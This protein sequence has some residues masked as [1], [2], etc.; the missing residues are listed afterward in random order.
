MSW[1]HIYLNYDQEALALYANIGL[2]RRARKD[3]EANKVTL[4]EKNNEDYL[5]FEADG[6]QVRLSAQGIQAASCNC[7]ALGHCKHIISAVLWLQS[8][9]SLLDP[10]TDSNNIDDDNQIKPL[11][12]SNDSHNSDNKISTKQLE[13]IRPLA[14]VLTELLSLDASKLLKK[15]GKANMFTAYQLVCDWQK[16]PL[17]TIEYQDSQIRIIVPESDTPIIY[18]A[19]TGFAG[20]ISA[21]P[22]KQKMAVHLAVIAYLFEQNNKI[23]TWPI[24]CRQS[25]MHEVDQLSADEITLIKQIQQHIYTLIKQGLSHVSHSQA[26]QLQL[27][28]M[29]ARSQGLPRLAAMLRHLCQ[30]IE[31]LAKRHFTVEE[32]DILLFLGQVKAYTE[33]LLHHQGEQLF[34]L[35]GRIKRQYKT[36]LQTLDLLPLGGRWWQSKTGAIGATFYFWDSEKQQY[37]ETT[38]A[39]SYKNNI[40]FNRLMVWNS[41]SIWQTSPYMLMQKAIKLHQPRVSDSGELSSHGS[42]VTLQETAW[43]DEN[44]YEFRSKAGFQNWSI[45]SDYLQDNSLD[46]SPFNE[47]LILHIASSNKPYI[48]EIRQNLVW[49]VLD[50]DGNSLFL[51]IFWD[52]YEKLRIDVLTSFLETNNQPLTVFANCVK[53]DNF[54]DLEPFALLYKD[55]LTGEIKTLSLDFEDFWYKNKKSISKQK[56]ITN[57]YLAHK[58]QL[59]E[60]HYMKDLFTTSII[61]PLL[62]ILESVTSSGRLELLIEQKQQLATLQYD[63]DTLGLNT[64]S[65]VLRKILSQP[66][67]AITHILQAVYLCHLLKKTNYQLPIWLSDL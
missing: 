10:I 41:M 61:Q 43:S 57:T 52:E 35:R 55:Q 16:N 12:Q 66:Q 26:E 45:L 51:C 15:A 33:M 32:Q 28:N 47:M 17:V 27:L 65:T 54:L 36:E 38:L 39:R 23:W 49:K 20:M 46:D 30:L 64:L 7:P 1:Q 18:M 31:L 19:G 59:G 60:N 58:Q 9:A 63:C 48:D 25:I 67:I 40:N 21:F 62:T 37:Q 50:N 22:T 53:N 3:I 2:V 11:N 13:T 29:S 34:K 14:N 42:T 44:Y 4:V 5:E 56:F 8:N 24:E 6:Q